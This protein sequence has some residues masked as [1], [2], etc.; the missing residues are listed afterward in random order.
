LWIPENLPC[1]AVSRIPAIGA[2]AVIGYWRTSLGG[3]PF[4]RS[5]D[6]QG[7]PNARKMMF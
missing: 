1:S 7:S 5:F 6:F 2:L 4:G 3:I